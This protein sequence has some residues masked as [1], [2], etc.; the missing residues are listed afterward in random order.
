M[1]EEPR[2]KQLYMEMAL[3]A[4]GQ[5]TDRA[6]D[7]IFV[8]DESLCM[9]Y[10]NRYAAAPFGRPSDEITGKHLSE[11]FP[12]S[13]YDLLKHQV[14][15]IF[16]LGQ[17]RSFEENVVFPHR[18]LCLDTRLTPISDATGAPMAVLSI[19]RDITQ[20]EYKESLI[21]TAKQEW[22]S[23]VDTMN[24]LLA[25]VNNQHRITRVNRALADKLGVT[26]RDA[27]GMLCYEQLHGADAPVPFC[28]LLQSA[29]NGQEH[30]EDYCESHLVG[31]HM[32][33]VSSLRDRHG[34]LSGCVYVAREVSERE[35]H[36]EAKKKNE[37]YMKLLLKHA[38]HIVAI[39]DRDG[40]Y[41]FFNASPEYGL[42]AADVV[43]R[44]P[45]DF[46][47]PTRASRMVERVMRTSATGQAT[48]HLHEV[49]WN[50]D[51]LHFFEQITPIKETGAES[52]KVVT[53][54]RRVSERRRGGDE[55][56]S[57]AEGLHGLSKR[58]AEI[59]KLI[60]SGLTNREI[61]GQLF[62]SGKTVATHRARIMNKLDVHKTSALVKYAVKSGLL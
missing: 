52:R 12:P 55:A 1:N 42:C 44:T 50:G 38:E 36:I 17:A 5:V 3:E 41:V 15:Q 46:F 22:E 54:A 26:V 10:L 23:A 7:L 24:Y 40:K 37:E 19:A 27:V 48:S 62:I 13:T 45:F 28:P 11:L 35:K 14:R 33:N 6:E 56:R 4:L 59:L 47:E 32:V 43:G 8:I 31:N 20:R 29:C 39:Q 53:I 49:T 60:A 61:A 18:E 58:E 9:R 57:L 51:T 34:H 16:K 2:S 30:E 21:S 25:V